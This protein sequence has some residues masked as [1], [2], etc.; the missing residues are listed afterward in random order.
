MKMSDFK[1]VVK[2]NGN[3]YNIVAVSELKWRAECELKKNKESVIEGSEKA[4]EIFEE[5]KW[6]MSPITKKQIIELLRSEMKDMYNYDLQEEDL[7]IVKEEL[8]EE[9][10]SLNARTCPQTGLYTGTVFFMAM[11]I[12]E[13]N[14]LKEV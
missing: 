8:E 14:N 13:H 2:I 3:E 7:E 10:Q 9:Y 12:A 6:E 4:R 1:E 5:V 11:D